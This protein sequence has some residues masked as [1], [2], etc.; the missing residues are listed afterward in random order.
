MAD[1]A[2]V[3]GGEDIRTNGVP[4]EGVVGGITE[5]GNDL[6]TLAE[7]Q[8][9]LAALDFKESVERAVVPL[10]V[11]FG[12]LAVLLASL[13]VVLIGVAQL[14]ASAFSL[15]F[16]WALVLVGVVALAGSAAVVMI[17]GLQ[18]SRSFESFRRTREELI[19]NLAW[20]RTVLV[21]SGRPASRRDR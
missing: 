20:I 6:M 4:P 19:R 15:N 2:S 16:G 10:M 13:P 17:A 21:Y 11:S 8:A 18:F 12:G 3:R 7:L 9:K 5:F 14:L 1:Q